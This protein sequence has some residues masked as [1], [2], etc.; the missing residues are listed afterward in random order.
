M[1]ADIDQESLR[2][3]IYLQ[4]QDAA[5][6][7]K[8]KRRIDEQ[9]PDV[10]LAAELYRLELESLRTFYSDQAL[11]RRLSGLGLE[12]GNLFRGRVNEEQPATNVL[13][14]ITDEEVPST[15]SSEHPTS[16]S[17]AVDDEMTKPLATP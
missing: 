5:A 2:L 12:N 10:E 16:A 13:E 9:P 8:G 4:S 6:L 11:C 14:D 7:V 1:D 3:S 15:R 17:S